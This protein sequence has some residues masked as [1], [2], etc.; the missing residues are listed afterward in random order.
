VCRSFAFVAALGASGLAFPA[1]AD[2]A[3]A[4][5]LA[6]GIG[7]AQFAL[8]DLSFLS[9]QSG[10]SGSSVS[11]VLNH[12]GAVSG[13]GLDATLDQPIS[14][15]IDG[16]LRGFF[17]SASGTQTSDCTHADP[18]YCY[19]PA[20]VDAPGGDGIF[21]TTD[22]EIFRTDTARTLTGWGLSAEAVT[23]K[24]GS[25]GGAFQWGGG[26]DVRHFDVATSLH[27]VFVP[28]PNDIYTQYDEALGTTYAGA[29][30]AA[31]GDVALWHGA[32]FAAS[33]RIGIYNAAAHY[34]GKELQVYTSTP[35]DNFDLALDRQHAA[36]IVEANAELRQNVGNF[37][38]ALFNNFTWY[39]WA[40]AIKYNDDDAGFPGLQVGTEIADGHM[41]SNVAGAK[42]IAPF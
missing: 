7:A 17:T 38:V 13:F 36:F 32:T 10:V 39:S 18:L 33:G 1:L 35:D 21:T 11:R 12:D 23:G 20:I 28:A 25:P 41:W 29:Y 16:R 34:A 14:A 5:T 30:L 37:T 3:G 8:P 15:A 31:R 42:L 40:P 26:V 4:P 27:S 6:V 19:Q 24:A 22:G 2:E 9:V